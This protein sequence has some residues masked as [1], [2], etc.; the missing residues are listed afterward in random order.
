MTGIVLALF[1]AALAVGLSGI[2][3][4]MGVGLVG[5][6]AAGVISEDPDKFGQTLLLQALPGTQGIYGLLT[7]FIIMQR[8]GVIGG[9]LLPLT[10]EQGFSILMASL[11]IAI[12]GLLSGI[13][14]GRAA[15]SGIGLIAKRPEEL[16]KAIIFAVMVETYAVLALLASIMMLFGIAV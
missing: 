15:A 11:P 12:V 1:G 5:Q 14:Q 16:G 7:G 8:I 13:Y 6:S 4:A 9:G 3:S 10:P 2:G